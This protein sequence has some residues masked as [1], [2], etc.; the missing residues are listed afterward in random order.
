MFRSASP[1]KFYDLPSLWPQKGTSIGKSNRTD[2]SKQ[3]VLTPSPNK[4][5]C[6]SSFMKN[7]T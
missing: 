1:A 2:F 3:N 4:Y 5:Q 6:K 7:K